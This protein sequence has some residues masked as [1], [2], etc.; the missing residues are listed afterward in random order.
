MNLS[1][2]RPSAIARA[3]LAGLVLLASLPATALAHAE[4]ERSTPADGDTV[5]SPFD[6]P[7]VMTFTEGLTSASEAALI[8][9]D[10]SNMAAASVD[11]P[12][13]RMTIELR[14]PL[15]PGEYQVRWTAIAEDGHVE[16]GTFTF[17]V[18]PPPPTPEPTPEPTPTPEV[19]ASP[20]ATPPPTP[21][22]E[23]SP[24]ASPTPDPATTAGAGDAVLP[25]IVAL[26][27]VVGGGAYLLTRRRPLA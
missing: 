24:V 27:I 13:A 25:I 3:L 11:G 14:A 4:L 15:D 8:G 12:G 2:L 22:P 16:R 18:S 19:S 9:P 17:T 7:I 21:S 23:P 1:S 6:G 10:G 26:V 20:T 5:E